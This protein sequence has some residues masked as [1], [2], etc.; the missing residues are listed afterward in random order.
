MCL[1]FKILRILLPQLNKLVANDREPN[2]IEIAMW[3]VTT[4]LFVGEEELLMMVMKYQSETIF[5]SSVAD[6]HEDSK[7]CGEF[8]MRS[9]SLNVGVTHIIPSLTRN[10]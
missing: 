10:C 6:N 2:M 1:E 7:Q 9:E 5:V 8:N 4:E 3:G